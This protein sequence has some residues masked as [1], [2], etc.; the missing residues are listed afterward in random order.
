MSDQQKQSRISEEDHKR[1]KDAI[2]EAERHTN[3][4]IFAVLARESDDYFYI[5]GFFAALWALM[6]GFV[7]A[8]IGWFSPVVISLSALA[9]AVLGPILGAVADRSGRRKPWIAVLSTMCI[10]ATAMLWFARR[11]PGSAVFALVLVA[12][13]AEARDPVG[14]RLGLGLGQ[15][16]RPAAQ[17]RR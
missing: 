9:V 6:I 2:G 13:A 12:V 8:V 10:A 1:I 4:E 7:V 17:P 16:P 14:L 11:E 3:G 15:G 5:A